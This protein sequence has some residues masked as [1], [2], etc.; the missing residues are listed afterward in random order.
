MPPKTGLREAPL[1][2]YGRAPSD[3]A[4]EGYV[5]SPIRLDANGQMSFV[6]GEIETDQ[7]IMGQN[8]VIQS[9][10]ETAQIA[11]LWI[12]AGERLALPDNRDYAGINLLWNPDPFNTRKVVVTVD[13][14]GAGNG[15]SR[16]LLNSVGSSSLVGAFHVWRNATQTI[17][18]GGSDPIIFDTEEFDDDGWYNTANGRYTPL[19]PGY[20]MFA[21][22]VRLA[23]GPAA[24]VRI[25][26]ELVRNGVGSVGQIERHFCTGAESNDY[27]LAGACGPVFADGIDDFFQVRIGHNA[28]VS[29]NFG[30]GGE[31]VSYFRGWY[32]GDN[33]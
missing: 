31:G 13:E 17:V 8:A 30:S 26:C 9:R 11:D 3:V 14:P 18:A 27:V 28:A 21:A 33:I 22:A 1:D 19:I 12:A 32:L 10:H 15:H 5:A 29:M 25:I 24:N 23:T 4:A 20:Y 6:F 7:I 2:G 16:T